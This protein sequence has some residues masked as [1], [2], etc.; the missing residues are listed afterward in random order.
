MRR[1]VVAAG[2]LALA[3]PAAAQ[4]DRIPR[5]VQ[6]G[7]IYQTSSRDRLAVRPFT[8]AG[9]L[10]DV[11]REATEVVRQ[12]LDFSDR[13]EIT[14][15][16]SSLEAGPVEYGPWND[17]GLV[18]LVTGSVEPLDGGAMLRLS[19]HDV[20]YGRVREIHTYRLPP[21]SER[22][23]RMAVHAASD[24]VVRWTTGQPGIAATRVVFVRG[25]RGDFQL[26]M[27]D[28]DG[29]NLRRLDSSDEMLYSPAWSPDGGRIAYTRSVAGR[30]QL[31]EL[32]LGSGNGRVLDERGTLLGTPTYTPEGDELSF[33]LWIDAQ[34]R[35]FRYDAERQCCLRKQ[36]DGPRDDLSPTYSPD[37]RRIAFNSNRLQQPHVFVASAEGGPAELLSPYQYGEPGYY[38]SPDWSPTGSLVAFHGRS[39]GQFQI[40]VADADRP[41]ATVRQITADGVSE[42]PSWAPDGRHIVFAGRRGGRAGLYVIDAVT[43]RVRPLLIGERNALPDWSGPLLRGESL[44]VRGQN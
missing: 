20:V 12:D 14:G 23:F 26:M 5:G 29:Q 38:T 43:G 19:L 10:E 3:A 34:Y 1:L 11:A 18:W 40:M 17:L 27:V 9:G 42:D 6:L 31:R 25:G 44:A 36:V 41:G 4:E 8:G 37:G 15:V 13:Y 22:D 33:S 32:D 28:S 2:I 30:W 24:D 21:P 35:I 16:P 7:L 39:R